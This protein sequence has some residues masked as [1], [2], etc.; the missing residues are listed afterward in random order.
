MIEHDWVLQ[1]SATF[2]KNSLV[3]NPEV[4]GRRGVVQSTKRLNLKR[5]IIDIEF[6]IHNDHYRWKGSEGIDIFIL[7]ELEDIGKKKYTNRY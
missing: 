2:T 5:W 3:L 4:P 7:D 6:I 1:G